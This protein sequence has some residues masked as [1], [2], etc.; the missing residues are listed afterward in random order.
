MNANMAI[1]QQIKTSDSLF[2]SLNQL[3]TRNHDAK[4]GYEEAADKVN[5]KALTSIFSELSETRKHFAQELN[6]EITD[7]GGTPNPGTSL[8]G[9]LHRSWMK[10]RDLIAS[11]RNEQEI[12]E[13]CIR[14]EEYLHSAYQSLLEKDDLPNVIR[15]RINKQF[16]GVTKDLERMRTMKETMAL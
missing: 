10:L 15:T 3:L 8:E 11:N 6:K 9:D 14:G 7:L 1:A 16:Y 5:N 4:K 13:E 12:L 2:V